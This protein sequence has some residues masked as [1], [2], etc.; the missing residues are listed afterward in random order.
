MPLLTPSRIVMVVLTMTLMTLLLKYGIPHQ[1]ASHQLPIL[2]HDGQP[3]IPPSLLGDQKPSASP[4]ATTQKAEAAAAAPAATENR[5]IAPNTDCRNVRGASDV[6][7]VVR[8]SKAELEDGLPAQLK[9]LLSCAPN[10]A[11]F[12]DHAGMV[13]GIPVYDALESITHDVT[14]KYDEF[15][16]YAKMK[17]D[18]AYSTS[19]EYTEALDRWKFLPMVYKAYK[20][21][22]KLR[23]YVFIEPD[24]SLTWTNLLQWLDRLD[25]RI[26]YYSG[27]PITEKETR[28]AQQGPGILLSWGA[29]RQYAKTYEERYAK[30]WESHV[31]KESQGDLILASAMSESHVELVSSFPLIQGQAPSTLEWTERHWCAPIVSW[32][33]MNSA[34]TDIF[35]TSLEKWTKKHGWETPY[36]ARDAFQDFILPQLSE[37]K[38]DWDNISSDTVIKADPDRKEKE[39]KQKAEQERKKVEEEEK[40]AAEEEKEKTA[41]T[42]TTT[43]DPYPIPTPFRK[44]YPPRDVRKEEH[45]IVPTIKQ[46]ADRVENCAA[47]C[48]ASQDCLQWRFTPNKGEDDGECHLGKVLR[49][50]KK[51]EKEEGKQG[52]WTSG[53]NVNKVK[54]KVGGWKSCD[55]PNWKFNQ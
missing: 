41:S 14:T 6:M 23:F 12:S 29:L 50:G 44:S 48:H 30:E 1:G 21:A 20:Q 17:A 53:W 35:Q 43:T 18:V 33:G 4:I 47:V 8:T 40:S 15:R 39:A 13:E 37:K 36:M 5:A 34:E 45:K 7:V 51:A 3:L 42:T 31:G 16:E 22:P 2:G 27:A 52:K 25:Y 10:V 55:K 28:M 38:E 54:K 9:T 11:I 49:L 24:T 26:Q 32:H 46:A 19:L